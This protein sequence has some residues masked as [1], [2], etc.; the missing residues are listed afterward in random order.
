VKILILAYGSRGD[1]Q[2]LIALGVGLHQAGHQVCLAAPHLYARSVCSRGL[3]FIALPG[4]PSELMGAVTARATDPLQRLVAIA[5]HFA[6]LASALIQRVRSASED[7][8]MIVH[9]LWTMSIGRMAAQKRGVPDISASLF[10]TLHPTRAFPA[11]PFSSLRLG[12]YG[13]WLSH[14]LVEQLFWQANRLVW[15]SARRTHPQLPPWDASFQPGL[16]DPMPSLY[17][18]SPSVLPRPEDWGAQ[19][20][21]TGYWFLD[22]CAD[23][24]PSPELAD[25]LARNEPPVV[26]GFGSMALS[27]AL[28]ETILGVL[29]QIERPVVWL[30]GWSYAQCRALPAHIIALPEAPHDWLLPR[31]AALVCHGGA[32]TVA[33]GL[34]FGLPVVTVPFIADQM[35]WGQRVAALGAGPA[36]VTATH[37]RPE[38]LAR[39]IAQAGTNEVR[40]RAARIGA[41]IQAEQGIDRA[42]TLIEQAMCL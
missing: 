2:P 24:Q 42:V 8:D 15:T 30:S 35:F 16:A 27:T 19:V 32:G 22:E 6:P 25:F 29:A 40:Q 39:A 7:A 11:M 41:C 18:I 17:A 36:P 1:V 31:S 4:D 10:P 13:N 26:V 5:R 9:S 34:R 38:R 37:L 28:Q 14:R 20:H 23:W 21:L 3:G 33:A 12:A